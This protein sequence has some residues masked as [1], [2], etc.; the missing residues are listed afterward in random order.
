MS[1][2]FKT[3]FGELILIILC[4]SVINCKEHLFEWGFCRYYLARIGKPAK[5][6]NEVWG[7]VK[8]K[9]KESATSQERY[10]MLLD[11]YFGTTFEPEKI[12]L[13]PKTF[14]ECEPEKEYALED[15]FNA[16][17]DFVNRNW[18]DVTY[19]VTQKPEKYAELNVKIVSL[20]EFLTEAMTNQRSRT[21]FRDYS[22]HEAM[23]K[24]D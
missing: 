11:S 12:K 15:L 24:Y 3:Y 23:H 4:H 7:A 14:E 8:Y 5:V 20:E 9:I 19:L 22:E 17:Y 1:Q 10:Q 16:T 21:F 2:Y 6:A 13:N 18:G